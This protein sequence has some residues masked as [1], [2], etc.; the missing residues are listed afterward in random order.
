MALEK[1]ALEDGCFVSKALSNVDL[2]GHRAKAISI[3]PA[4]HGGLRARAHS[5]LD[6]AAEG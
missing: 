2:F 4:V 5:R 1:I 6:R 3:D